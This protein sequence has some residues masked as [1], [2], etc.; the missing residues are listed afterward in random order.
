MS[1]L[2][3]Q[4]LQV[5]GI[6]MRVAEQG[7]G[8]LVLFCHVR[9]LCPGYALATSSKVPVTGLQNGMSSSI[10]SKP[11]DGLDCAAAGRGAAA[12][13]GGRDVAFGRE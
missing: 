13:A 10:S 7:S 8:P 5:N 12:A 9:A 6:N 11:L 1:E 2:K 3:L 4:S